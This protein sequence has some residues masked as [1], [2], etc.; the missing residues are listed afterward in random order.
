MGQTFGMNFPQVT[1][2]QAGR[3]PRLGL[4]LAQRFASTDLI[5][6]DVGNWMEQDRATAISDGD[7]LAFS[8]A[9]NIRFFLPYDGIVKL[10]VFD[11][12]GRNVATLLD[13]TIKKGDHHLTWNR[14]DLAAGRVASGLYFLK[15][16]ATAQN[17]GTLAA[18]YRKTER[19]V[20]CK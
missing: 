7:F 16:E 2:S 8:G 3:E 11:V 9:V 4:Q 20:L 14:N 12:A 10:S 6:G 18:S 1:L 17:K 5:L 19:I 13:A 15:V